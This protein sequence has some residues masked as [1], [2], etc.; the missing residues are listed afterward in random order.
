MKFKKYITA[1]NNS[2]ISFKRT[3]CDL[4]IKWNMIKRNGLLTPA[5]TQLNLKNIMQGQRGTRVHT[6]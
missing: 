3:N 1:T 6:V 2:N 5:T 4:F